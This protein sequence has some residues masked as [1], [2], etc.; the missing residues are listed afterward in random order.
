MD[1]VQK[2]NAFESFLAQQDDQSWSEALD[3]L[4]PLVHPVD[5]DATRIWF[6]FWPLQLH[7]IVQESDDLEQTAQWLELRGDY[8]LEK[9]LDSSLDFLYGSRYWSEVHEAVCTH[10][11]TWTSGEG[12]LTDQIQDIAKKIASKLRV[13]ES[14]LNGIT[15]VAL[16][17]LQQIGR[18]AFSAN[19]LN[20]PQR[21][22]SP[23][24]V[25]RARSRKRGGLL[26]FLRTVDARYTVTFNEQDQSARFQA[27]HGQ[28]ISMAA[29]KD[30]RDYQSIDPRRIGG[31]IPFQCRV[32][33]CGTCWIGVLSGKERLS[34][35]SKFEKER[36]KYFGYDFSNSEQETHPPIR[37]ACQ[38][39]CLGNVSIAIAPWNGILNVRRFSGKVSQPASENMAVPEERNETLPTEGQVQS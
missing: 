38:A 21:K 29:G 3:I 14:H 5:Q 22:S 24:R 18:E 28:D 31:P 34:Q 32:A 13:P 2:Q 36:L 27:I 23:E 19:S 30:E 39:K 37:L 10:A 7:H 11:E 17:V 4:L 33:N 6:A 20:P 35:I 25:L 26:G 16:M 8:R 15:A 9:Q 12:S 1:A